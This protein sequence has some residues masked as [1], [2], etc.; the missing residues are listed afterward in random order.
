M[1]QNAYVSQLLLESNYLFCS[2]LNVKFVRV[3]RAKYHELK[4]ASLCLTSK[5]RRKLALN[6]EKLIFLTS[7]IRI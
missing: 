7:I 3:S 2:K 5:K 4:P 1:V 6:V